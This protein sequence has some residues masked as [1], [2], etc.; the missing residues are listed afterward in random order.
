M[1]RRNKILMRAIAE[2]LRELREER[3]FSQ[4]YVYIDTDLNIGKIEVGETNIS[5]STLFILC[6]Y[7]GVTL[8]EFFKDIE[9]R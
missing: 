6:D 1:Q 8:E 7:Y 2:R 9:T 5:V 3:G 4:Q